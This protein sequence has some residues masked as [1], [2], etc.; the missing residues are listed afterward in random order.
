M[1]EGETAETAR[2]RVAVR[3]SLA[4][5]GAD[6]AATDASGGGRDAFARA[7][8]AALGALLRVSPAS[9]IE[10]GTVVAAP[11]ADAGDNGT[12]LGTAR[13]WLQDRSAAAIDVLVQFT[14]T[15]D[16]DVAPALAALVGTLRDPRSGGA[17]TIAVGD[18]GAAAC[19][20]TLTEPAVSPRDEP[21]GIRCR[22]GHDAAS[23]LCH[24]CLDGWMEAGDQACTECE[25]EGVAW[26]RVVALIIALLVGV[27]AVSR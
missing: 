15:V 13:R 11:H 25:E 5:T 17:R 6:S 7:L 12:A 1:C 8:S 16:A 10:V 18:G 23:P 24:V 21:A 4:V 3:L 26:V 20:L 2:K 19:T 14:A 27:L 22:E 9:D